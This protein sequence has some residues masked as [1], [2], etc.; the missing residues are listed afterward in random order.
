M[1]DNNSNPLF[2]VSNLIT[3]HKLRLDLGYPF[4]IVSLLTY[5]LMNR[6][7]LIHNDIRVLFSFI[8]I[9]YTLEDLK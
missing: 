3:I 6:V 5:I 8:N 4:V 9:I 1:L 7:L 2:I